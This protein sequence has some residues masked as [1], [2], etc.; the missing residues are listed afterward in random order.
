MN[1]VTAIINEDGTYNVDNVHA[2]KVMATV[3]TRGLNPDN[4]GRKKKGPMTPNAAMPE[5]VRTELAEKDAKV[6]A[7]KP[8]LSGNT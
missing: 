3:D 6:N 4:K 1:P 5:N 8:K 2:G 7:L